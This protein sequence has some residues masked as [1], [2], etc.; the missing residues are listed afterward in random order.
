M[1]NPAVKLYP[2]EL[3]PP[4]PQNKEDDFSRLKSALSRAYEH[5]RG[6]L[7]IDSLVSRRLPSVLRSNHWKVNAVI[8]YGQKI[9]NLTA[10]DDKRVYGVAVDAG[11]T[12]VAAYLC[13]LTDGEIKQTASMLNPQIH[14]GDGVWP[15]N[16]YSAENGSGLEEPRSALLGSINALLGELRAKEGLVKEQI[17]EMVLVCDTVTRHIALGFSPDRVGSAPFIPAA[18][19]ALD[20]SA[21]ELR[22]DILPGGNIHCLAAEGGFIGSDNVATLISEEIY[23]RDNTTMLIDIGV[24]SGIFLGNRDK[25]YAASRAAGPA[26]EGA[27]IK[28]GIPASAGAVET[29]AIDPLTLEPALGIIGGNQL[30]PAGICGS[31]IIDA[32]AQMAITGIIEPSGSFSE[33]AVSGRIRKNAQGIM[34]Y[35]LY[36]NQ[37]GPREDIVVTRED[38]REVQLAKAAIYAGAKSLMSLCGLE[39]IGGIILAGAFGSRIDPQSAL[40]IGLYPD[41][42]LSQ[43]QTVGNAAV[44]GAKMALLDI[45]KRKEAEKIAQSVEVVE[46][47]LNPDYRVML[48]QATAIPHE[49]DC[50]TINQSYEWTCPDYDSGHLTSRAVSIG[51]LPDAAR[52]HKITEA[53]P[54]PFTAGYLI[55]PAIPKLEAAALVGKIEIS[56]NGILFPDYVFNSITEARLNKSISGQPMIRELLGFIADNASKR[57]A[58]KTTGPFSILAALINP[59]KLYPA[60]KKNKELLLSTLRD[61]TEAAAEYT[62]EALKRRVDIISFADA[63]GAIELVG[64]KFY[65]EY[66][67][68][69]SYSY[70]KKIEPYLDSAVVHI[71]GK[72]SVSLQKA[73]FISAAPYRVDL[74]KDYRGLL[75]DRASQKDFK[76]VGHSCLYARKLDLPVIHQITLR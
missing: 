43:V 14:F 48:A 51:T 41:C 61:V 57:V 35:V 70:L 60:F 23:K 10:P 76:F 13:D 20:I 62:I 59:M 67:G 25:I 52:G 69:Y 47:A 19:E 17:A 3:S 1:L 11:T 34:E 49:R 39:K 4:D 66:C 37:A 32:V 44:S 18:K 22:L 33:N 64:E 72:T 53:A 75:F 50:F 74:D 7:E 42:Q 38:V 6:D 29:V 45:G 58:L 40:N 73:G 54:E 31:G 55:L 12:T 71:C 16:A 56:G 21:R 26:L 24:N 63:E 5:L 9:I 65:K 68:F 27:R 2:V 8:L 30:P 15:R 36:F 46:T 28:C